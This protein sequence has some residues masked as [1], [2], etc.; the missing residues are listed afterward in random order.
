MEIAS[1]V[2]FEACIDKNVLPLPS[3]SGML[4]KHSGERRAPEDHRKVG[5]L[6]AKQDEWSSLH[7]LHGWA[8][9]G[10]IDCSR[11]G[12]CRLLGVG[13]TM[14]RYDEHGRAEATS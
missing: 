6:L 2:A 12:R 13:E 4:A 10:A 7:P 8:A 14:K 3:F 11:C 5:C 9:M 1:L